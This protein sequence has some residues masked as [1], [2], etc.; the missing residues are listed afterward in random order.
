MALEMK[1]DFAAAYTYKPEKIVKIE[2]GIQW[3]DN[4]MN[5]NEKETRDNKYRGELMRTSSFTRKANQDRFY[6][7]RIY[8][9]EKYWQMKQDIQKIKNAETAF[10]AK[11]GD[12]EPKRRGVF[13]EMP[14]IDD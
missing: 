3:F 5:K 11:S 12:Q 8:S 10:K 7:G 6:R 1:D 14:E 2:P 9:H 13:L 4:P